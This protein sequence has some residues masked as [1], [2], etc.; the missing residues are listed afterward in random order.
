MKK[1]IKLVWKK[2]ID[3][4][5]TDKGVEKAEVWSAR[6]KNYFIKVYPGKLV[7]KNYKGWEDIITDG[8]IKLDS[9]KI[10]A[11]SAKNHK[12]AMKWSKNVLKALCEGSLLRIDNNND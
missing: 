3:K 1:D 11:I 5:Y 6:Y 10:G 4:A 9:I 8:K 12:E 7:N 2:S